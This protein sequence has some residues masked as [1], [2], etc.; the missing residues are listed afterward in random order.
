MT[1]FYEKGGQQ[2]G[3]VIV[4]ELLRLLDSNQIAHDTLVWKEGMTDW[5]PMEAAG[6]L[7]G[8]TGE[9]MVICAHSGAV[10]PKSAMIPYGTLWVLPE[11]RDAFVQN[12][13]AGKAVDATSE[14][15]APDDYTVPIGE[16]FSRGW[17][18]LVAD[19]WPN[20]GVSALI[21]LIYLV[22]ANI[23]LLGY[24]AIL[25]QIPLYAGMFMYYIQKVR[26]DRVD[27]SVA[28]SGFSTHFLQLM[29]LG[30]VTMGIGFGAVIP[31]A[32][33]VGMGS[34]MAASSSTEVAGIVLVIVG[35]FAILIPMTYIQIALMFSIMLCID[36]KLNFWPA[37]LT[38]IRTV[39]KHWF[40]CF[41]FSFVSG[42]LVFAGVLAICV[43]VFIAVP[44]A[45]LAM[46]HLYE[47]V[48]G[49]RRSVDLLQA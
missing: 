44:W 28:F 37:M 48:Y 14:G 19:F 38:S 13:M 1:W 32:F 30:L 36:R 16:C 9:E 29:L 15:L 22:G 33:A 21:L 26:G 42:L 8:E 31:G 20:V 41:L 11:H 35:G 49:R 6:V 2:H 17:Q 25:F 18:S 10:R 4:E 43:G 46:V 47:H 34:V 39:N 23:P 3:P 12:L 24:V 27:L 7:T 45:I 5:M 40:S